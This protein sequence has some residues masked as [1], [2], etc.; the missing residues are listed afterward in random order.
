VNPDQ[1]PFA[2]AV[3]TRRLLAIATAVILASAAGGCRKFLT[4]GRIEDLRS[5]R[6]A[7]I[8]WEIER[9][10]PGPGLYTATIERIL[11]SAGL[12][13]IDPARQ[14]ADLLVHVALRGSY[15]YDVPKP[16]DW[17]DA[18]EV[19]LTGPL[20]RGY[21]KHFYGDEV[22]AVT[23]FYAEPEGFYDIFLTM[24]AKVWGRGPALAEMEAFSESDPGGVAVRRV[25]GHLESER[26]PE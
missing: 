20:G 6:T 8:I 12:T 21:R 5:A 23:S 15:T 22:D 19:S 1:L 11:A 2:G 10:A 26:V 9:G 18:G 16:G 25:F 17:W 3:R 14:R 13:I 24:V 4:Q 7:A